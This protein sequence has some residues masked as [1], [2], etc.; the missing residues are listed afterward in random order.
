MVTNGIIFCSIFTFVKVTDNYVNLIFKVKAI[1]NANIA[2]FVYYGKTRIVAF[3]S[4]L[5]KIKL[6]YHFNLTRLKSKTR[7][8]GDCKESPYLLIWIMYIRVGEPS[9][10]QV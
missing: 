3:V 8:V 5:G 6:L 1:E 10:M 9:R 4:Y 2:N 7:V